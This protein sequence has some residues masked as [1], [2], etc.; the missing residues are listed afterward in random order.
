MKRGVMILADDEYVKVQADSPNYWTC[1]MLT[2]RRRG[3]RS[4]DFEGGILVDTRDVI[5]GRG[6]Y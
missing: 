5:P 2:A 4:L 1:R 3:R 6:T